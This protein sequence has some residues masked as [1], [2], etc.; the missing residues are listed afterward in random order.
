MIVDRQPALD[1]LAETVAAVRARHLG[2]M[3]RFHQLGHTNLTRVDPESCPWCRAA[4]IT[5]LLSRGTM[6]RERLLE[7][8]W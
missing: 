3:G 6:T 1:A 8:C 7:V 5:A 2:R 4:F